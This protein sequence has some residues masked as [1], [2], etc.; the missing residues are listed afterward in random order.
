M[1]D[2]WYAMTNGFTRSDM[3]SSG[4]N[5]MSG[6][7][8]SHSDSWSDSEGESDVPIFIPVPF[9]ELSSIQYYSL[10]EQ[11]T[12]MTA[13]LKEQFPRHCFIRIHGNDTE[14]LLVPMVRDFYTSEQNMS[15]YQKKKLTDAGA[16][17]AVEADRLI[18]EAEDALKQRVLMAQ[19]Q[20]VIDVKPALPSADTPA[21]EVL[22]PSPKGKKKPR[23]PNIFDEM[24]EDQ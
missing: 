24:L 13:A 2:Q 4:S 3:S 22:P 10:D 15:W 9:Q 12:E 20:F 17:S 14:P 21:P 19:G 18:A 16:V 23:K 5:S 7:S 6:S 1:P 8:T 11:L